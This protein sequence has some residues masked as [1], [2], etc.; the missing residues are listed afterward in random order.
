MLFGGCLDIGWTLLA[1]LWPLLRLGGRLA[2]FLDPRPPHGR[3]E[4]N[5]VW[6][7]RREIKGGVWRTGDWTARRSAGSKD[8][9]L[10]DWST[11]RI[12]RLQ[13]W[14]LETGGLEIGDCNA[15]FRRSALPAD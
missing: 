11:W 3:S 4:A 8:C 14:S 13:T 6:D 12:W 9:R 1:A 15:C 2:S 7:P 10:G 5:P